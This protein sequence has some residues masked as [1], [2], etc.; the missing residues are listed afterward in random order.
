[1]DYLL[2]NITDEIIV[3]CGMAR[4]AD[5]LGEQYAKEMGFMVHYF[6]AEWER[7]GKSAGYIRSLQMAH[8]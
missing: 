1:M 3:V 6:P 4:G 7:Y 2:S 8:I 5:K